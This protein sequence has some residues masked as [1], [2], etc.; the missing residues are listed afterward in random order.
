MAWEPV[1]AAAGSCMYVTSKAPHKAPLLCLV[2]QGPSRE[3]AKPRNSTWQN[4]LPLL[5]VAHQDSDQQLAPS[6]PALLSSYLRLIIL[7]LTL[8]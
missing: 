1:A 7:H 5:T 4:P 3:A 6:Q 2:A 8:R